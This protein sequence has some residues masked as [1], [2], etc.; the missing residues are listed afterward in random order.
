MWI[1]VFV[2]PV[3]EEVDKKLQNKGLQLIFSQYSDCGHKAKKL[4]FT[5]FPSKKFTSAA[6]WEA[7][8]WKNKYQDCELTFDVEL[9][10]SD[11]Y[12]AVTRE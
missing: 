10:L 4:R 9:I 8:D 6:E 11:Y 12:I 3:K 2:M 5:K 7:F 1:T